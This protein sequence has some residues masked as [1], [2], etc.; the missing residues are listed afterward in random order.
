MRRRWTRSRHAAVVDDAVAAEET[1]AG[2]G[3]DDLELEELRAIRGDWMVIAAELVGRIGLEKTI[4]IGER[5]RQR[6]EELEDA[7]RR[8]KIERARQF[9]G[10]ERWNELCEGMDRALEEQENEQ[11]RRFCELFDSV[12]DKGC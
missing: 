1:L 3:L 6:I 2:S 10:E 9:L 12:S 7:P 5:V 8:V 11:R 4:E